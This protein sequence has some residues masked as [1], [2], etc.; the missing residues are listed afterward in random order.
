VPY[1]DSDLLLTFF[2]ESFGTLSL[3][4]RGGRASQKRAGGALEPFHSS[5]VRFIDK[6]HEISTLQDAEIVTPRLALTQ[7]LDALMNAGTLLRW[8]RYLAPMRTAEPAL[9]GITEDSLDRF[10]SAEAPEYVLANAGMRLLRIMGYGLEF[11]QCVVCGKPR[12]EGR[13]AYLE[14]T[15]GGIVCHACSS[16][17]TGPSLASASFLDAAE[18]LSQQS[19]CVTASLSPEHPQAG[20]MKKRTSQM[21]RLVEQ[22]LRY[23]TEMDNA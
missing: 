18:A 9:Y 23:H 7:N 17:G 4:L 22:A 2:T 11:N 21:L 8:V 15:R 12:P 19:V 10:D 3:S 6:G 16:G 13:S 14:T 20:A 5:Y 1:R